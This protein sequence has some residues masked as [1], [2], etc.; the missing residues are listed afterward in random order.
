MGLDRSS[1]GTGLKTGGLDTRNGP[2]FWFLGEN[3]GHAN[4]AGIWLLEFYGGFPDE[5]RHNG[6]TADELDIFDSFLS[7]DPPRIAEDES[8][9]LHDAGGANP[10]V[11]LGIHELAVRS[12]QPRK[13]RC[14][15]GSP[16]S[17]ELRQRNDFFRRGAARFCRRTIQLYAE[18]IECQTAFL[19]KAGS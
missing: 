5:G 12:E 2:A 18:P 14:V 16:S 11:T 8:R 19:Q 1:T 9:G 6:F 15:S 7:L 17:R 10:Q 4:T 13:I 3:Y